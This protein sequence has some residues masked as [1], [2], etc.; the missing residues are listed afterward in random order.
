MVTKEYLNVR[1]LSRAHQMSQRNIRKIIKRLAESKSQELIHKD[2]N[3]QWQVHHILSREFTRKR[4][5]KNPFYAFS[6]DLCRKYKE[7]EINEVMGFICSRMGNDNLVLGYVIENK[8]ANGDSHLHCYINC[9]Q[10]RELI[11]NLK[12]GFSG[13]SYKECEIFDLDGWKNYMMKEG[14]KITTIKN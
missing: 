9:R 6:V 13:I 5:V 4:D 7:E 8:K 10:K 14:K 1:E 12:L 3:N 2:A 11:D